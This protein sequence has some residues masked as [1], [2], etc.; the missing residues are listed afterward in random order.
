MENTYFNVY[1]HYVATTTACLEKGVVL[2]LEKGFYLS[3]SLAVQDPPG[4]LGYQ[5][6]KGQRVPWVLL[7]W[8]GKREPEDHGA[9]GASGVRGYVS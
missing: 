7:G 9:G 2:H 4:H 1:R 6:S 5:G 8:M 3:I